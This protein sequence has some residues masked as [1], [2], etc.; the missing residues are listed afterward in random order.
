MSH[1]E[2]PPSHPHAAGPLPSR[3]EPGSMLRGNLTAPRVKAEGSAEAS[4]TKPRQVQLSC[5][6]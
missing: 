6:G 2:H 1:A 4:Y 3:Q 5:R